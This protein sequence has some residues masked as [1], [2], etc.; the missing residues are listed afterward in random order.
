MHKFIVF[1][2]DNDSEEWEFYETFD[3]YQEAEQAIITSRYSGGFMRIEKL[4]V[5]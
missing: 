3:T 2:S 5:K 1:T 4:W